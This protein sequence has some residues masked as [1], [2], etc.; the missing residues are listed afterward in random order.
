MAHRIIK[1]V[2]IAV[3]IGVI[4]LTFGTVLFL[5]WINVKPWNDF[6]L[7]GRGTKLNPFLIQNAEELIEFAEQ[8]NTGHGFSGVYFQQVNDIDLGQYDNWIP[9]GTYDCG[10]AFCGIYDGAG[11]TISNLNCDGNKLPHGNVG[12]FGRLGGVVCNLGIESGRL[13]GAYI[14]SI[15]SHST[16]ESAQIINCYSKA[17]LKASGRCG[18]IA[19]NFGMGKLIGCVFSG[20][21]TTAGEAG[22]IVS[23]TAE[24]IWGCYAN[25][26][27]INGQF[28]GK[29]ENS[30][31]LDSNDV[32]QFMDVSALEIKIDNM[33][34][35]ENLL[36]ELYQWE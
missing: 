31:L 21:L 8:V 1:V 12:L 30:F 9:I 33:D 32:K 7:E 23:Y 13:E 26:E 15:A 4:C 5:K 20:T 27:L 10:Y 6:G 18:G 3:A 22:G 28:D 19:D 2:R 16:G 14:G 25:S 29:I 24:S 36:P 34:I 17:D 11:H 35:E